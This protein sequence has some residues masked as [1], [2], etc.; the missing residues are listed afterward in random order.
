MISSIF[1]LDFK[2]TILFALSILNK[3][4]KTAVVSFFC[5]LAEKASRKFSITRVI[6]DT[7]TAFAV[8]MTG[9]GTGAFHGFI[10]VTR[11]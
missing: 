8:V 10:S 4:S 2:N 1:Y 5:C 11:H 3:S 7:I 6:G 9:I